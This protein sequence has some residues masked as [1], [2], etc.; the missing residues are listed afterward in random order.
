MGLL[1]D[2]IKDCKKTKEFQE[3][4]DGTNY[5]NW[6][7]KVPCKHQDSNVTKIGDKSRYRCLLEN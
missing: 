2:T 3:E 4:I 6:K 1:E 7:K 5:C